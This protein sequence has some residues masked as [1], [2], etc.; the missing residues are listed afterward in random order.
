MR[1]AIWRFRPAWILPKVCTKSCSALASRWWFLNFQKKGFEI[2]ILWTDGDPDEEPLWLFTFFQIV[3][4]SP[5]YLFDP[6]E[7]IEAGAIRHHQKPRSRLIGQASTRRYCK[8][9]RCR[10][11]RSSHNDNAP[12]AAICRGA[13]SDDQQRTGCSSQIGET[14]RHGR[15]G[16]AF[17]AYLTCI[18]TPCGF[19]RASGAVF[20]ASSSPR[21]LP[22]RVHR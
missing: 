11:R 21:I 18:A 14:S 22:P 19:L 10:L 7:R 6:S 16:T 17:H 2:Y 20:S 12:G 3:R 8:P 4:G 13:V 15:E 9:D 5:W 1:I